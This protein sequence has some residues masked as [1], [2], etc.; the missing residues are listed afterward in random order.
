MELLPSPIKGRTKS[1]CGCR[2]ERETLGVG[3]RSKVKLGF[4][5]DGR[6]VAVKRIDL[7]KL[8]ESG[9]L[10]LEAELLALQAVKGV[11]GVVQYGG[12]EEQGGYGYMVMDYYPK[13]LYT[14]ISERQ[15]LP[16]Y[17]AKIL[18]RQVIQALL[19]CHER[20]V[21]HRDIKLENILIN[22]DGSKAALTDF[23][24]AA[25]DPEGGLMSKFCGS[26]FT[27]SPEIIKHEAYTKETDVW[28]FGVVLYA[29]VCG[30]F[31]FNERSPKRLFSKITHGRFSISPSL[32]PNVVD[33]ISKLLVV[34][35]KRRLSFEEALEHPWFLSK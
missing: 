7:G 1:V 18:A 8:E 19:A 26:P 3:S 28:S 15:K 9:K 32:S 24:F 12:Y 35:P 30:K 2:V 29:M 22:K 13:D 23:G 20:G 34:N 4:D 14:Y 21:V 10:E 25:I 5:S 33:L 31:P 6:M 17:E 11:E 27:V 16:E